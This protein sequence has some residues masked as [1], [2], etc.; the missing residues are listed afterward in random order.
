MEARSSGRAE[1]YPITDRHPLSST[2]HWIAATRVHMDLGVGACP[3]QT[4]YNQHGMVLLG[5]VTDNDCGLDVMFMMLQLPQTAESRAA[6]RIDLSDYLLE[7]LE[8]Y[9]VERIIEDIESE[10]VQAEDFCS[11]LDGS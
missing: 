8:I 5:T 3:I 6:L 9:H 2:R 1:M 11:M 7:R 4:F 10:L